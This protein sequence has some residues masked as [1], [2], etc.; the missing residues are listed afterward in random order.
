MQK[1]A[2]TPGAH[3]L[4]LNTANSAAKSITNEMTEK[5]ANQ[6]NTTAHESGICSIREVLYDQIISSIDK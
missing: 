3:F 6:R 2:K 4:R 5:R 1:R